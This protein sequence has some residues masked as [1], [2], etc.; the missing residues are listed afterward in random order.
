M[1]FLTEFIICP[2]VANSDPI[3]PSRTVDAGV[4]VTVGI[5]GS[6]LDIA[7]SAGVLVNDVPPLVEGF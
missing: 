5:E 3:E 6:K 1:R 7:L 2:K 4:G